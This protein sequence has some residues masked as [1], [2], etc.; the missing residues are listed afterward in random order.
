[1]KYR[2]DYVA[3]GSYKVISFMP[4]LATRV[5]GGPEWRWSDGEEVY[6]LGGGYWRAS[7]VFEDDDPVL[8]GNNVVGPDNIV[9]VRLINPDRT[10]DE[11][12]D[13]TKAMN[14]LIRGET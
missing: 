13:V 8:I 6:Y 4:M 9:G 5:T 12:A 14:I 11:I 3:R 10:A 7:P 2:T 1:M